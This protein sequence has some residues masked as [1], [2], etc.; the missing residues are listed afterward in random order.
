MQEIYD[1]VEREG[2]G[3]AYVTTGVSKRASMHNN[4]RL[5]HFCS[6]RI[7]AQWYPNDLLRLLLEINETESRGSIT[8]TRYRGRGTRRFGTKK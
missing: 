1:G 4:S 6:C 2:K 7:L 3:E 8:A 5:R